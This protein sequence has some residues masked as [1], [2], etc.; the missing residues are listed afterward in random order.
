[1][2]HLGQSLACL[3]TF[4]VCDAPPVQTVAFSALEI[5]DWEFTPLRIQRIIRLFGYCRRFQFGGSSVKARSSTEQTSENEVRVSGGFMRKV[6]TMIA[7]VVP[8]LILAVVVFAATFNVN[9][10]RATI[11]SQLE[12]HLNRTVLLGDMHLGIFPPL[13]QIKNLAI[14]D[15]PKFNDAKPFVEAQGLDVSV[16]LLPLLRKSVEISSLTLQRPSVELIKDAQGTVEL[17]H[18]RH[19]PEGRSLQR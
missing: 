15:D 5:V 12:K 14:A 16:K 18:N 3:F 7:I 6:R 8:I 13:L 4:K 9:Q 17:F 1:M 19:A 10:Y 11:Q 2:P